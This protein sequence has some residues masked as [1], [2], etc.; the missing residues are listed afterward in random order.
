LPRVPDWSS[1]LVKSCV[2]QNDQEHRNVLETFKGVKL[3]VV[4]WAASG[5][6]KVGKNPADAEIV[7][8]F[9]DRRRR[10]LIVR[11][12][13]FNLGEFGRSLCI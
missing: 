5:G 7:Q 8:N 10:C 11:A 1:H 13:L 2:V 12:F 4:P 3:T 6:T 9:G